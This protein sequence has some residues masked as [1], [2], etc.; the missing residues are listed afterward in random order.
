MLDKTYDAASVEP[1]IYETWEKAEAF[2]AG[3]GAKD[4]ADAF[5]I[6]IPP[7]N[8]TGSLHMG[9]ALNNTLQDILVRWKRM[10]GYDVLWQPGTDHAG[11]ATQMV[12]E[13]ELAADNKPSRRDM[14]REAF[15]ERVW[16]QKRKSEGTILGQLKRLGASCD[17][18]R[19]EFTMSPNLSDAVLKVFVDLYK[20]GLIYKSKR[21]V[22]WDPKFETAISDLEVENIE[23]DGHM[24]HFKYPLAGGETY[25]YVEKDEDGNV[26]LRETRDYI[27]IA[28]T[29]PE[30]ML[31]DGAV[32]VHPGDE[33][34]KPIIGKLCE[35]PVGPKEHRRLIPI[36]TDEYP[37]PDFGSGA[38]KITGA[39]DFN[40]YQ[41]ALRGKIPMYRLM[42]TQGAM[43]ADGAPYSE[44]AK[45]A[46]ALIDGAEMTINEID[47]INIVPDELR[48]LDRFAARKRVIDQITAEG[49]AVMVPSDHPDVA[50]MKG[51]ASEWD[52]KGKA[53]VQKLGDDEEG[54]AELPMVESKK[55]M[56]PF[57]D[58]SKVVIEP[59]LTDQWFVD[60]KTLAEPALKAVQDGETKFVPGNWD[61]TYYNWLNDIQPWCISR[62]L[63][64]GHQIPVWY[65][66]EGNEYCA[67]SEEEAVEMSGGK[68]LTRDED[69]LDTWF[70]SALWPFSTLGW[71]HQTPELER[72]Y[73][74]D[75]LITGFD[76]IFFWVARM[77]MQG[78]HFMKEVPFH[79]VYINSI[80]VDKN[81]KKMSKSLGNVLDPLDLIASYGADATRYALASQ[82]VQ[83]RRTLRMSDQAAEGGQRF[84]TKLWNAA[85]FAEM[86]GCARVDRFD[87]S[88]ASHTLNRWIATEMGNCIAEVTKALEDYRFNDASGGIYRFT[89]NTFCDWYLELAKP[90]FNGDD[91]A[92]K[93]E[94]R[95]TAAWAIDEI[96]KVLHPFMPFLTE[97]LWERLGD[98]GQKADKLLM[99][100]AWPKPLVSDETAAGEI[101]WLVDLISEIRSVRAEMNIPA[102][103][104]VQLVVVGANDVTQSRI[105]THEPAIQRLARAEDIS[106][107]DAAPAG[108]AQIII[109]EATICLPLAGVIDL[110]AEKAR[111]SKDAGKLEADISKIEKKLSNPKFVE[112]APDEVVAG[113]REKVAESKEKLD[114]INVALSRLAEIG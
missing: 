1:R 38:V 76:I 113:E 100:S 94:T 26:T 8:V 70:S 58:R 72:Y 10:Q 50:W 44:E 40:D 51:K 77:M 71:P 37:D 7:P 103:A 6:V 95:A 39:H 54:P 33:R 88:T 9:H 5:T 12:V 35:I 104:K 18:S 107:A 93:A 65:D 36:I 64:W 24:W 73:K 83:G 32:A 14:G 89:W 45:K 56:Q 41:V 112:K 101:N 42:D 17:W 87:P 108:S 34:Y 27:S 69:V 66:E 13:R 47:E 15:I 79:T 61:K 55:I 80:V 21:L 75:V 49:L 114:K 28:T 43:R 96:L 92:A 52:D 11:I 30:T 3:A 53:K 29:R 63:W 31:G 102:G 110:A 106:M 84:A 22:N 81:G 74:T 19:T 98:E 59:M 16:E 82:E 23:T 2:K 57:G 46:Q 20:E 78:I 62:Q 111:L 97:E 60:A 85:R 4:G 48:G 86:N 68:T 109:G 91:E 105:A 90:I 99:L 67:M 25:E